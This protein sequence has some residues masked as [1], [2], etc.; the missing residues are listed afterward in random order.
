MLGQFSR[1]GVE[2]SSYITNLYNKQATTKKGKKGFTSK[3][4]VRSHPS[5]P[6]T[7][8]HRRTGPVWFRGAEVSCPNIFSIACPKIKWFCPNIT[9]FLARIWLFEK[10]QGGS[11]RPPPPPASY[12]Y[13][14]FGRACYVTSILSILSNQ[15]WIKEPPNRLR[16]HAGDNSILCSLFRRC[17]D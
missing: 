6:P 12:A 14:P 9:W 16:N 15:K 5:H 13:A 11:S 8:F 4:G 2:V 7:P 1:Q 10:F 3:R 17:I